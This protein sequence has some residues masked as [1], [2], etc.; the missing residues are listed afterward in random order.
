VRLSVLVLLG[1]LVSPLAEA[2]APLAIVNPR[3]S[4]TDGGG[5]LPPGFNHFPG[6]TMFFSFQVDG[7]QASAD[8][9]VHLSYTVDAYDPRGVRILEP[10]EAEVVDTLAPQDKAWKPTVRLEIAI[11]PLADSGAYKIAVSVKDEIAHAA[12]AKEIPFEVRGHQVDPSATLV[13]RNFRFYRGEQDSE[14]LPKPAYRP[15]DAVWARFD[16]TGYK[17]GEGNAIDVSY[18]VAVMAPSG[19]ELWRQ[20]E[21]AVEKTQSFYPKRYVPGSMSLN[22]QPKIRPGEYGVV[23]TAHDRVGGQTCE[24]RQNFTIE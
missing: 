16:I 3:I 14:P 17:Y 7:Y 9:K 21:A 23:I 22:L 5:A 12:A 19:K 2:A 15:G 24:A 10:I 4:D 18:D 8:G 1:A 13:V 20:N 6:E 11:P